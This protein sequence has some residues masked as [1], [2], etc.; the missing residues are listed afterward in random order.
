M[1]IFNIKNFIFSLLLSVI[2]FKSS[3]KKDMINVSGFKVY[4][5]E[6]EDILFEHEA[7][8]NASVIGVPNPSLPGSEKEKAYIV[9][10]PGIK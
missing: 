10:K 7:I 2:S 1:R 8:D 9:L 6:V 3:K 4:P 5:R